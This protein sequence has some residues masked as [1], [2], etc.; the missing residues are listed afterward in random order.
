MGAGDKGGAMSPIGKAMVLEEVGGGFMMTEASVPDPEPGGLIVRQELCGVCGTDVHIYQGHMPAVP[1]PVVLGHEIVGRVVARGEGVET[2]ATGRPLAT[3]DLVGIKPGVSDPGDYYATVA[4]QPNLSASLGAY[5]FAAAALHRVPLEVTGGFATHQWIMPGTRVYRMDAD[6]VAASLLEPLSVG[7]HAAGRA[8]YRIGDTVVI[9]GAG[10]IGLMCLIGAKEL[11]AFTTIVIGAPADRLAFA[12]ELGADLTIDIG[13][14][15]DPHE[16]GALVRQASGHGLGADI[17]IEATGVLAALPEGI[18]L[19]RRGGQYVTCGH[20]TNVGDVPL[21]PWAHFT[22]K[23]ITLHG[24]WGST[25]EHFVQA[26]Q[27]IERGAYPFPQFVSHQIPLAR[28]ADGIAAMGGSYE[29]DG[30]PV[31]KVAIRAAD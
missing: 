16:R 6:P 17:V 15:T 30:R 8:R 19:L 18:A 23:H 22:H 26:R 28:A 24:V 9:Q 20:F 3:G 2:D 29:L 25:H 14:V 12:R 1:Q 10:P 4:C 7:L 21:N 31:R 11:G 5:G 27:L 13:A